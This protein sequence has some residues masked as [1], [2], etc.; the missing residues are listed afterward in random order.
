MSLT[1]RFMQV[2]ESAALSSAP[3]WRS[4]EGFPFDQQMLVCQQNWC[5]D[6]NI[7]S[8]SSS[9]ACSQ[10]ISLRLSFLL[11]GEVGV[12]EVSEI[13]GSNHVNQWREVNAMSLALLFDTQIFCFSVILIPRRDIYSFHARVGISWTPG[14]KHKI[15]RTSFSTSSSS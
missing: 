15:S 2:G 1:F 14:R 8:R 12:F 4:A 9:G 3:S 10:M 6:W 11:S 7:Y 5:Q 13:A